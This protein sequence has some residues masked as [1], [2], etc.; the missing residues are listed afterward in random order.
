MSQNSLFPHAAH[1]TLHVN[2]PQSQYVQ[3]TTVYTQTHTHNAI[4]ITRNTKPYAW[5]RQIANSILCNVYNITQYLYPSSAI[6]Q[7]STVSWSLV[8]DTSAGDGQHCVACATTSTDTTSHAPC[9]YG[10]PELAGN[11]GC[12]SP[13][14]AVTHHHTLTIKAY[15]Q[16]NL[17][18]KLTTVKILVV[19]WAN[20]VCTFLSF[21]NVL[22]SCTKRLSSNGDNSPR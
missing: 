9:L 2:L 12:A 13:W 10:T 20:I 8:A 1:Q 14:V 5:I 16:D 6:R 17:N 7:R 11:G 4:N 15:Q 3:R 22:L 21:C 18:I 19:H